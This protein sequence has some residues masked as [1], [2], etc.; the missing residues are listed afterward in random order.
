M[1]YIYT[2]ELYHHGIKGQR[3]G[4]RRFQNADG[5]L[6]AAGKQRYYSD[7]ERKEILNKV[8]RSKSTHGIEEIEDAKDFLVNQRKTLKKEH[9]DIEKKFKSDFYKLLEDPKMDSDFLEYIRKDIKES[10]GGSENGKVDDDLIEFAVSANLEGYLFRI[11]SKTISR[12]NTNRD[13]YRKNVKDL[14]N[15]IVGKHSKAKIRGLDGSKKKKYSKA[16]TM[17]LTNGE[18]SGTVLDGYTLVGDNSFLNLIPNRD[19]KSCAQIIT[20][21]YKKKYL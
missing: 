21:R 20:Q 9:S 17:A 4:V 1:K 5:T 13:V 2:S 6:T 18:M 3:W 8:I 15:D 10:L 11:N 12:Y 7:S 16:V 14:T 19:F